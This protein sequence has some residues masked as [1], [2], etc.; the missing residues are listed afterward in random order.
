[1]QATS[2]NKINKHIYT[3]QLTVKLTNK[4]FCLHYPADLTEAF[5]K[6][7]EERVYNLILELWSGSF[8]GIDISRNCFRRLWIFYLNLS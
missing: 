4:Q 2:M 7:V 3:L 6:V 1:M 5:V 8:Q